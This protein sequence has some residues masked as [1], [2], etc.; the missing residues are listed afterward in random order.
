M[1]CPTQDGI[2]ELLLDYTARKLNPETTAIF[3]RHMQQC[4]E[5]ARFASAQQQLWKAL[6]SWEAAPL[7]D[8]FDDRLYARIDADAQR[9]WWHRVMWWQRAMVD[10]FG[11]KP[12]AAAAMATLALGAFLLVPQRTETPAQ[13]PSRVEAGVHSDAIEPEQVERA[14]EDLEM[15]RQ[16]NANTSAQTTPAL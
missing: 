8:D 1:G 16:L 2:A 6:D 12:A 13:A 4:A 5:C 3:E 14:L 7:S 15:L 9:P 11:W 10:G